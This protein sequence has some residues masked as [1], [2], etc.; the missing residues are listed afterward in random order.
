[1]ALRIFRRVQAP[2]A[3]T[4]SFTEAVLNLHDKYDMVA[5]Y[6]TKRTPRPPPE[7]H[8][9]VPTATA[10]DFVD[11]VTEPQRRRIVFHCHTAGAMGSHSARQPNK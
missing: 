6:N 10:N 3:S 1:M 7:Q 8:A 11:T 4:K 5:L 9:T 2:A